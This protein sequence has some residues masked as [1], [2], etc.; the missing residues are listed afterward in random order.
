MGGMQLG[1]AC[2]KVA[3]E[4]QNRNERRSIEGKTKNDRAPDKVLENLGAEKDEAL[5]RGI[6]FRESSYESTDECV[7]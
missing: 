3:E 7:Q 6:F 5:E 2:I 1:H 4:G